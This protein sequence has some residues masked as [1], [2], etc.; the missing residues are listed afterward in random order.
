MPDDEGSPRGTPS[1]DNGVEA[2]I[3]L[4]CLAVLV[5]LLVTR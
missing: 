2:V 3:C 1:G 5:A 4:L